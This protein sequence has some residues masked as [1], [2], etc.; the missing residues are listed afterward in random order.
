MNF[1]TNKITLFST[2]LITIL[3]T[4][5]HAQINKILFVKE[6][7]IKMESKTNY[8]FLVGYEVSKNSDIAIDFSGGP[9]KFWAGK[10]VPVKKGKGVFNFKISTNNKPRPGKG[11]RLVASIR[12]SG[13]DWKTTKTASLINNITIENKPTPILDDV[14]FSLLMP[15]RLSSRPD[16]EY[17]IS[18]KVSQERFVMVSI[19]ND[20]EWLVNSEPVKIPKGTGTVKVNIT[21]KLFPEGKKYR[22]VLDLSPS[23]DFSKNNIITKEVS[24]I[25]LTKPE[26]IITLKDLQTKSIN[27]KLNK[28]T[29]HLNIPGEQDYELIKILALNGEIVKE[30]KNTKSIDVS[31]LKQGAYYAIVNTNAF[32]RFIK[33]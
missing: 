4:F 10:T 25:V 30:S 1:N 21:T 22:F 14:N 29:N 31:D 12:E 32:Y 8:S 19:W 18:F 15:T 23:N 27:L 11:Y 5:S 13:G 17:D 28:E 33:F 16:Y 7:P 3:T 26:N 6:V 2:F 20:K 9:S 24:G